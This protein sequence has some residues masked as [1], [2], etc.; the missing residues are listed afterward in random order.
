M[1]TESLR[2]LTPVRSLQFEVRMERSLAWS[3]GG[4]GVKLII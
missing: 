3:H 2:E 1:N 4:I